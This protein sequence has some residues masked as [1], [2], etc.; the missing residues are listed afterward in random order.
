MLFNFDSIVF[1]TIIRTFSAFLEFRFF[2]V[3]LFSTV[4]VVGM[5]NL[6]TPFSA[7]LLMFEFCYDFQVP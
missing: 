1:A 6:T 4:F 7:V 5:L 3:L 2:I